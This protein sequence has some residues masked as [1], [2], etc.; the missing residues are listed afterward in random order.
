[1][2]EVETTAD[3]KKNAAILMQAEKDAV[4]AWVAAIQAGS[5]AF[6]AAKTLSKAIKQLKGKPADAKGGT[7]E[8]LAGSEHRV[9]FKYDAA[10]VTLTNVGH[11]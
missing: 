10:T 8:F 1:M 3:F 4:N 2:P 7:H 6:D 5:N 11:L 9:F